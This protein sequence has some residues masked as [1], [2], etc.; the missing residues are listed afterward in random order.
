MASDLTDYETFEED[1]DFE[2]TEE[3]AEEFACMGMGDPEN[4]VDEDE[5]EEDGE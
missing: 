4:D 2:M 3:M 5:E 1:D